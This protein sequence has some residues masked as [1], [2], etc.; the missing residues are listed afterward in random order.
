MADVEWHRDDCA[1]A[2]VVLPGANFHV[3]RSAGFEGLGGESGSG[4]Y[5]RQNDSGEGLHFDVG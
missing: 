2:S 4:G 3:A 1:F 5:E